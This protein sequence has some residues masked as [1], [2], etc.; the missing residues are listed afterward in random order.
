MPILPRPARRLT[1]S[2]AAAA[3]MLA[4]PAAAFDPAAMTEAE[5]DAFR[6]EVR[7][8]LLDHPE[9]LMEAIRVLEERQMEQQAKADIDALQAHAAHLFEDPNS[10]A[11]GNLEGDITVVEF[12]D[13]RCGY[14]KAMYK[15]VEALVK[16]DGNIRYVIKEYPVLGDVSVAAARF[17]IALRQIAGD[18]AYKQAHDALMTLNGQPSSALFRRIAKEV[19]ADADA[20]LARMESDEVTAV[21]AA[22]HAL[23]EALGVRGTPNFVVKDTFVRGQVPLS[24]MRKIVAQQREKG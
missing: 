24:E 23:A 4:G 8:Y 1:L 17:T 14:C 6:T 7:A 10:W 2:A 13:Y 12:L 20:V 21:I 18:A 3:L 16:T 19:G 15:D 22:N 9:V 11:G 5:R